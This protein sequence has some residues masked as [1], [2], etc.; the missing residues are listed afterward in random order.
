MD[1]R[2]NLLAAG[3]LAAGGAMALAP[4]PAVAQQTLTFGGSDAVGSLLDRA[5]SRFTEL[6]NERAQGRLQVNFIQGE[7]LGND[8]DV[9]QQM[10]Q[11][12]VDLYGDVLDWYANW[13]QDFN[14]LNWGFTFRD[15]DHMQAFLDSD[16]YAELAEELRT[17]HGLRILAAAPTQPRVLFAKREVDTPD[18]L[19][20]LK[21]RVPEIRTYLLLW[22]TLGTQ[23]S[24][25]AWAEVY[26]GLSTGTI[27]A[28]EGPVSAAYAQKMHQAA[29]YVMR[30]DHLVST[31][32]ITMNEAAFQALDPDL[33]EILVEAAKE[34]TSWARE[35][36]N[37]ETEELI[38]NMAGEGATVVQVD[39]DAFAEKALS[40][41]EE[42]ERDG[43]WS[44]GLWERIRSM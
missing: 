17:Q 36:A 38:R 41:V 35:Q 19:A 21:M 43:V 42:L 23:P 28:A 32:H 20:G 22:Q 16:I 7:Q 11:G 30:T 3:M 39:R 14:I 5:N 8:I 27:E 24:R 10:M 34:A 4:M 29:P 1:T 44:Q 12:S 18:D 37:T 25:V 6:V 2:R 13:V 9:I 31:H 40:A 33:Q 26:L 15:N